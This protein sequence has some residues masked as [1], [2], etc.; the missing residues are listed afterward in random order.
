M[1][2]HSAAGRGILNRKGVDGVNLA[3]YL[4]PK[5]N[6]AYLYDDYTFRQGLEKMRHHGYTVIPVID[7]EGRYVGTVSEGDFLWKILD[8]SEGTASMKDMEKLHVR[9]IVTWNRLPVRITADEE[10]ILGAAMTQNFVSVVD[11]YDC[12]IGIVTRR[13]IM[14]H[15]TGQGPQR[16]S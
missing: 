12:F 14:R 15:L 10:K 16:Q 4:T 3:Y 6:V 8:S 5:S 1:F 2:T 7:R 9:D 11:D 13:D